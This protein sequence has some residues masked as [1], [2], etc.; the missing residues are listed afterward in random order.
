[1]GVDICTRTRR[2]ACCNSGH[3]SIPGTGL[4]EHFKKRAFCIRCFILTLCL[5]QLHCV[6]VE[7][8][9]RENILIIHKYTQT[10]FPQQT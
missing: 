6:L 10:R 1:M 9:S 4:H 3:P 8:D 2:G 7:V 5:Y